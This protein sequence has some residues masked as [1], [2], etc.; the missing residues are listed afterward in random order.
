[1]GAMKEKLVEVLTSILPIVIVV[2]IL[3]GFV[4]G[5]P[6]DEFV[7]FIFCVILVVI[8]FALFL[9]G[10]DFGIHPIGD[11]IGKE[12]PKR[13]SKFFMIAV[14][15]LISFLVTIAE[16]DV[17]VFATQVNSLFP[18][19]H[20]GTLKYAIAIGVA[21]FLIIAAFR[22]IYRTSLRVILTVSYIA[23][24]G[25]ALYLYF[26][27]NQEFLGIAFDS[28]GVT[29]GPVTVPILLALGIGI[30]SIGLSRSKLEGFGMVGLA[31]VGPILAVL[32]LGVISGGGGTAE[33][34]V[35]KTEATTIDHF[36]LLEKFEESALGVLEALI[37]LMIFFII[38]QRM[39]LRYSWESV[40]KMVEGTALAGIGVIIF[41]T[42]VYTGFMPISTALGQHLGDMVHD[43]WYLV[44]GIG[45]LL[46]F[47]VAYAEPA[48]SILGDQ[49][50]A[51]SNGLLSKRMIVVTISLG[52]A[53]LVALGMAKLIFNLNFIYII[54]PGYVITLILMWLGDKDMVGIAFDAGGVSTGPM[55]VA[56]L[57][58]IYIGLASALYS[59]TEAVIY[60]FGLIALIALAPCLFLSMMGVY[61]KYKGMKGEPDYE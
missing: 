22:I 5:L 49:V 32:I 15:F 57:S 21:V 47:L 7:M 12:I 25:V 53:F 33:G 1:M 4:L 40:I 27:G 61:I 2:T 3:A 9:V 26:S 46:G 18:F 52:V 36:L 30:C 28:G 19:I 37:P 29:T 24:M 60:G 54:I 41:L 10:V 43:Q 8:G 31:S 23:V 39:F 13:K 38:F 35:I 50:E 6:L 56:I 51:S 45:L 34:L 17:S 16:P 59:G 55:S 58:S 44:I 20:P 11:A 48:V 42:G 14:V